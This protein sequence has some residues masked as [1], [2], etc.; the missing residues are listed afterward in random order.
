MRHGPSLVTQSP[1]LL[2]DPV[3]CTEQDSQVFARPTF[4]KL[5][6]FVQFSYAELAKST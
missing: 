6:Q 2:A 5:V 3:P 4:K 1:T